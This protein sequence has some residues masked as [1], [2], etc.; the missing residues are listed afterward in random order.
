MTFQQKAG[1]E[2]QCARIPSPCFEEQTALSGAGVRQ[3]AG[4]SQGFESGEL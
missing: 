4:Q 1:V 2:T 3:H